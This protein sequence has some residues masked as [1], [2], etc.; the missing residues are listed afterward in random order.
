M[1]FSKASTL[2]YGHIISP[3][4][5]EQHA[6][7]FHARVLREML[8]RFDGIEL[9]GEVVTESNRSRPGW[10]ILLRIMAPDNL[11]HALVAHITAANM[12]DL[13]VR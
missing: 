6:V 10:P 11:E 9:E 7:P 3:M 12:S 1:V 4:S 8:A 13:I 2:Y 5:G